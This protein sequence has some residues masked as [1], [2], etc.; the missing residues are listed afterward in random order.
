MAMSCWEF[1]KCGREKDKSC[2]A[3]VEDAGRSCWYVAGTM[4][5]GQ[6]QGAY[7]EKIGN[8][9]SCDFYMKIQSGEI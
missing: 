9:Q 7:A 4:C 2:S 6:V 1:K 3:V 5:G 8:C